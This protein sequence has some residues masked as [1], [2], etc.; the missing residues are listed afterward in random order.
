MAV[1]YYKN[2]YSIYL[3]ESLRS[4]EASSHFQGC[5][6]KVDAQ[7]LLE[8]GIEVSCEEVRAALFEM[9]S[10]EVPGHDGF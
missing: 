1:A 7:F 8:L 10:W 9:H 4:G 2:L 3:E 6:P 5:F